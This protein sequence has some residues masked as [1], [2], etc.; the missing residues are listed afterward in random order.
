MVLRW[1]AGAGLACPEGIRVCLITVTARSAPGHEQL[2]LKA[3]HRGVFAGVRVIISEQMQDAVDAQ[4]L[5]LG[6]GAVPLRLLGRDLR[7][8]HHV[9]E[10][11]RHRFRV[12]RSSHRATAA[13]VGWA[14]LIH[15][16]C[17]HVRRT[18]LAHPPA[19]Q[20]RHRVF[21][22]QQHGQLGEGMDTQLVKYMP[23]EGCERSLADGDP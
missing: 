22:N 13:H 8:Q 7:T 10:Q 23:R 21:V 5:D 9:P 16:E 14:Q 18:W 20:I 6:L 15:G 17:K 4:Q 19:V 2:F 1:R 12:M 11:S 3:E